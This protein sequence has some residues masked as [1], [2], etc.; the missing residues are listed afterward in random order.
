M[1]P[2]SGGQGV[3]GG[4]SMYS[5]SQPPRSTYNSYG[6]PG[7]PAIGTIPTTGST[8]LPS[9]PQPAVG[10]VGSIP[11]PQSSY[12]VPTSSYGN[13]QYYVQPQFGSQQSYQH[14]PLIGRMSSNPGGTVIGRYNSAPPTTADFTVH[15]GLHRRTP[16]HVPDQS[17]DTQVLSPPPPPP[18]HHHDTP[19]GCH[20][21]A[22]SF[23]SAFSM[24]QCRSKLEKLVAVCVLYILL[25]LAGLHFNQAAL[26]L[27]QSCL[28][29]SVAA[30]SCRQILNPFL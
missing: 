25:L 21:W 23:W 26:I 13:Q 9:T 6:A 5:H 2:S 7:G 4:N 14:Q 8:T 19:P 27:R 28:A 24:S 10:T 18:P 3:Q 22:P 29:T 15:S 16:N 12:G 20:F 17:L 11:G 1:G 30:A